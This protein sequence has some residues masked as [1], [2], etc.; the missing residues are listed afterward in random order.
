MGI[1]NG[2]LYASQASKY[3]LRWLSGDTGR[4]REIVP[5]DAKTPG[6]SLIGH[7]NFIR[8]NRIQVLGK[9]ELNHI[10][11]LDR[12]ARQ[13]AMVQLFSSPVSMVIVSDNLEIPMDFISQ[14]GHAGIPLLAASVESRELI[15]NLR[16]HLSGLLAKSTTLH[17]V[18]M[19][20]MGCGV[21]L[22]G[23][24][25]I[26]KSELALELISRGHRLVAD[27]APEFCRIAPDT[28]R[29]SC[30]PLLREFLEVRGLGVLNV[31]TLFGDSAIKHTKYLRL[32]IKLEEMT[33]ETLAH[34]D[35]LRGCHRVCKVLDIPIPE[36]TLPVAAGRNLAVV[37]ETAIRNH[38]LS[39]KGYDSAQDFIDRQQSLVEQDH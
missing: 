8:P 2:S 1:T 37:V 29:G 4:D 19:E 11:S 34:I 22:T 21:L 32:I 23:E 3:G 33:D 17:G 15:S 38:L 39:L 7:L 28:I 6:I 26:G 20:V 31:R 5:T 27:D 24:S 18:F 30:P 10:A 9:M 35:R 16:Y 12:D 25:G 13:N 14:A 36:I